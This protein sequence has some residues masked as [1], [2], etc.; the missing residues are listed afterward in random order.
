MDITNSGIAAYVQTIVIRPLLSSS[1]DEQWLQCTQFALAL[2]ICFEKFISLRTVCI[3]G[4]V[5]LGLDREVQYGNYTAPLLTSLR[6]SFVKALD[7]AFGNALLRHVTGLEL[8]F[9]VLEGFFQSSQASNVVVPF[10]RALSH[11]EHLA[12]TVRYHPRHARCTATNSLPPQQQHYPALQY[13][14]RFWTLINHATNLR[15]LRIHC[16]TVLD[17]SNVCLANLQRLEVLDMSRV[18]CRKE[19]L[20]AICSPSRSSLV[21]L[22]LSEIRL[23]DG[24]WADVFHLLKKIPTLVEFE[25]MSLTYDTPPSHFARILQPLDPYLEMPRRD[26]RDA[27]QELTKAVQRRCVG[28]SA[29]FGCWAKHYHILPI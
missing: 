16:T 29:L 7:A 3:D 4:S 6:R 25:A 14:G 23:V 11:L 19:N 9:P 26:D 28:D 2:P 5:F 27:F 15:S 24:I 20:L 21:S 8:D 17:L 18:R 1:V 12:V 10:G 22:R 13:Q